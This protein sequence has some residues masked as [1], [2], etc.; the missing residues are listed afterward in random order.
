MAAVM[1]WRSTT[2]S[3]SRM[4]LAARPGTEV[5]PTCSIDTTGTPSSARLNVLATR[6]NC[7]GHC[8]EYGTTLTATP[9]SF[10]RRAVS[11]TA[12]AQ[13]TR[14]G[15]LPATTGRTPRRIRSREG[16]SFT[17]PTATT[18]GDDNSSR[19]EGR[20]CSCHLVTGGAHRWGSPV[21]MLAQGPTLAGVGPCNGETSLGCWCIACSWS[22]SGGHAA[23]FGVRRRFVC[24]HA[25]EAAPSR[26]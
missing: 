7:A 5:E 21:H 3:I 2:M 13:E 1:C 11:T 6:A 20:S 12:R 14:S 24:G 4:G 18:D 25:V 17:P 19:D 10:H 23:C 22:R 9:A 26:R 16:Q 8:C 15:L